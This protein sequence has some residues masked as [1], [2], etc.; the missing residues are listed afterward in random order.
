MAGTHPI[1]QNTLTHMPLTCLPRFDLLFRF[2]HWIV[3][4]R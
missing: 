1:F 4:D 2:A 3:D